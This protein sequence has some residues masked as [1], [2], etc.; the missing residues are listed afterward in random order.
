MKKRTNSVF[1]FLFFLLLLLLIPKYPNTLAA[2]AATPVQITLDDL[3]RD[4]DGSPEPEDSSAP[5]STTTPIKNTS[6]KKTGNSKGKRQEYTLPPDVASQIANK[7][8]TSLSKVILS[9]IFCP[10]NSAVTLVAYLVIRILWALICFI[11]GVASTGSAFSPGG[12]QIQYLLIVDAL[13]VAIHIPLILL[14]L[15]KP[16]RYL[17]SHPPP[18]D[19]AIGRILDGSSNEEEKPSYML[20]FTGAVIQGFYNILRIIYGF[21]GLLT[22]GFFVTPV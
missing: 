13:T 18:V 17:L 9:V 3:P 19:V 4:E 21:N 1:T 22:L 12:E 11:T 15:Y 10:F 16:A 14:S 7:A 6:N 8:S 20:L 2:L 5:S